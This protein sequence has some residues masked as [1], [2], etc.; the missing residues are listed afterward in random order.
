MHAYSSQLI[1]S[2]SDNQQNST[3]YVNEDIQLKSKKISD[4]DYELMQMH[5]CYVGPSP[6]PGSI[7][8]REHISDIT[9]RTEKE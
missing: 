5:V 3:V 2:L 7:K 4:N 8:F 1:N 6:T 9:W